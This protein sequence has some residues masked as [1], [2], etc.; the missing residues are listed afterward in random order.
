MFE[1]VASVVVTDTAFGEVIAFDAWKNCAS[2]YRAH[3]REG[4]QMLRVC[5]LIHGPT[6]H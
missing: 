6:C 4:Q 5:G 3:G 2:W 1:G